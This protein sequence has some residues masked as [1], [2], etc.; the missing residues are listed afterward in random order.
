MLRAKHNTRPGIL[1]PNQTEIT[2]VFGIVFFRSKG[3]KIL[4]ISNLFKIKGQ[5]EIAMQS[6]NVSSEASQRILNPMTPDKTFS[7]LRGNLS[8]LHTKIFIISPFLYVVIQHILETQTWFFW[9]AVMEYSWF[10]TLWLH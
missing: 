2:V 5:A 9:S 6:N 3:G 10:E 4:L 8:T 1:L 7:W